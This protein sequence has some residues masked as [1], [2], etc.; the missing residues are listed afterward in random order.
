MPELDRNRLENL[1]R[2]EEQKFYADHPKSY[3]L[4]Q[5]ARKSLQGGVP[6][7]WMIR[8]AGS[9]PVFVK[10]ARGAHFTDV[11]GRDYID[12]CLGDTGAMTGHGPAATL[13]A[14]AEQAAKGITLM[15]PYED[16]ISVGEE[17]QRR[18]GLPLWQFALTATDANRH[19]LRMARM[20]TGRPK[21]LVFNYCYHGTVDET[22]VIL[23]EEG[24][25]ISRPNNMGPQV[26]PTYT[27]K[28]IEFNDV[29]AL[30]ISLAA[31]DVAAVLA[32]PVMTNIGIIHPEPGYHDY[33]REL[34]RRTGTLLI[35]DE[36]H[37]ICAG[38]GGYTAAHG[39]QPD[40]LTVGKPLAGGVP[41]A[42]Y[43][44]TQQVADEFVARLD[45]ND[46]D[47]GGI[48]GTLAGNAL[49][50]AAM[51][52]T[53]E[54]VLTPEFYE[55]AIALQEKFTAGVESV[56]AEYNLPWIV[57]R[58]GNRSEYWFRPRPP[59]NGG[60]AAAAIDHEL[61]RYMHLYMLNRGILMTPFH[62]MALISPETTQAD[63][64]YHTRIFRAAV[65][66]LFD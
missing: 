16:V 62:N 18:F 13:K 22:F 33:L 24:T 17:L 26:D 34:T 55:K 57:K 40:F 5:R 25:P 63:V 8:W 48:G 50:I 2:E 7:L 53:L 59:R 3:E 58:L 37:T 46:S 43:G 36:T 15:L 10:E 27:T 51:K 65:G 4:Y 64:D 61:D 31:G 21:V 49:S 32:E 11:D 6:M 60:E 1:L 66:S 23:D 12:F 35:I 9:F 41:A 47:V 28:V 44:F 45:V 30:E 42:V 19:V 20:I 29:A 56:I 54:N 14:I 38:P 52:A 39:L